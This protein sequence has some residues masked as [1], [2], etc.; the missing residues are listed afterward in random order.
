[1]PG[2]N[3]TIKYIPVDKLLFD[4][5]NPRLPSSVKG[6]NERAVLNW[7]LTDATIIELMSSIGEQGYF[8]GEPLLAIPAKKKGFYEVI[9]GNRRLASVKLL[10]NPELAPTKAKSVQIVSEEAK[11]EP[12]DVLPALVYE[13]R[14]KILDYLGYRHITGIKE[15]DPL[16]KARYLDQLRK[17]FSNLSPEEQYRSLARIIGSRADYVA[18][19]LTGFGVYEYIDDQSFFKIRGLNEDS[20]DFSVF[21]TALNYADI[22]EFVGLEHRGDTSLT[23]LNKENLKL[24]ISWMFERYAEGKTRLGE[25]RNLK[26]L[27]AIVSSPRALEAFIAGVPLERAYLLTEEPALLFSKAIND[28]KARL[29]DAHESSYLVDKPLQSDSEMLLDVMKLARDLRSL[30]ENKLFALETE[31]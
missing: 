17:K 19:L 14:E 9:E 25:S 30:V 21:T 7:M 28:A 16:A 6:E 26:E 18:R 4:P 27:S 12:P 15:W 24:L 22:A 8:P 11:R 29:M 13:K 2:A 5:K 1:M 3:A 31:S 10:R 23:H 20:F